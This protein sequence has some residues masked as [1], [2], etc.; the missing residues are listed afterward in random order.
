MKPGT[1]LSKQIIKILIDRGWWAAQVSA[2]LN[3]GI[4]DVLA[5]RPGASLHIE[6]K[7]KGDELRDTQIN[8]AMEYYRLCGGDTWVILE[9]N[10]GFHVLKIQANPVPIF[11]GI[12]GTIQEAVGCIL[13]ST[14]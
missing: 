11:V 8:W 3:P 12:C 5:T 13:T 14:M 2:H 7:A 10:Y 9:G 4:P 1:K 6:V